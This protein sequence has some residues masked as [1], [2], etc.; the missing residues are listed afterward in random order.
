MAPRPQ[1]GSL[2]LWPVVQLF[3]PIRV[4]CLPAATLLVLVRVHLDPVPLG[5]NREVSRGTGHPWLK[6]LHL[7]A[8]NLERVPRGQ[9]APVHLGNL[10]Q[11]QVVIDAVLWSH[12]DRLDHAVE[13]EVGVGLLL[14]W[15]LSEGG[16]T[17]GN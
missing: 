12:V 8:R 9:V 1:E 16:R 6:L 5:R 10:D 11:D 3:K 13:N 7:E 2:L 14:R 15:P 17:P 4:E